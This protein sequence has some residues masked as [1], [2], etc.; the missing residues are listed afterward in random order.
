MVYFF[1]MG[2]YVYP[3]VC[4]YSAYYQT[5]YCGSRYADNSRC[6]CFDFNR[7]DDLLTSFGVIASAGSVVLGVIVAVLLC[8]NL[9]ESCPGDLIGSRKNMDNVDIACAV[10]SFGM[11]ICGLNWLLGPQQ[12]LNGPTVL[13][14]QAL[15]LTFIMLSF[16]ILSLIG[17]LR[18]S[19]F[20]SSMLGLVCNG[21]PRGAFYLF[22]GFY[23]WSLFYNTSDDLF[24][25]V[26]WIC[27]LVSI[28]VGIVVIV[29][30][31][32]R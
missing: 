20:V 27:G 15:A 30:Q 18:N 26:C 4:L 11:V 12:R 6:T 28:V 1:V 14:C 32:C 17:A 2:F 9:S 22:M 19:S 7:N 31:C 3:T 21:W 5:S 23:T 25:T 24:N 16:G 29:L 8:F 13:V 10:A